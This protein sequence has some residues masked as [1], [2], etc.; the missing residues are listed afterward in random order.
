M[1]KKTIKFKGIEFE[2]VSLMESEGCPR[3]IYVDKKG[4]Y[5]YFTTKRERCSKCGQV[6]KG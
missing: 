6:V 3:L 1:A 5:H 2:E 4:H